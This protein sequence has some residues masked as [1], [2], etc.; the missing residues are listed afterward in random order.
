MVKIWD[1]SSGECLQT[2]GIGKELYN[3]SFDTI[4]LYLYTKI[5]TI[6]IDASLTL[7]I[8]LSDTDP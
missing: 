5:G 1:V 7:N 6:A 2:L 3:I 8:P 4:S